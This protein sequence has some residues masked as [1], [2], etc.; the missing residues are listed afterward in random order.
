VGQSN[1]FLSFKKLSTGALAAASLDSGTGNLLLT[2]VGGN[3]SSLNITAQ[4]VIKATPG[5]VFKLVINAA[6]TAGAW[7]LNDCST[8]GAIA[9]S[10]LVW[11]MAFGATTNVEGTIVTIDFPF[12]TGIVLT[13]PT[14]AVGSLSFI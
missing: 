9:A 14:G 1:L 10:N 2:S 7:A 4:T 11:E 5:R 6:G 8:V 3:V 12:A 13:V